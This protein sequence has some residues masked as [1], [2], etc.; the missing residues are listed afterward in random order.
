[1][2]STLV[3]LTLNEIQAIKVLFPRLPIKLFDEVIVVDGGSTD[4][5]IEFFK[6]QGISV[7]VQNKPG[8]GYAYWFGAKKAQGELIVFFSGDGNERAGDISRMLQAISRGADMVT[9]TRFAKESKSFDAT[10]LR[11]LGNK[12]FV[13]LVN[14]LFGTRLTDV[15]NAFRAVK[16]QSFLALNLESTG[17]DTEIEMTIKMIKKGYKIEEI[18]T[19][20]MDRIGG[21]AKLQTVRDGFLNLT[22]VMKEKFPIH[23]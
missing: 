11:I 18:P 5:T 21:E 8:H 9:A 20:E 15:L 16:R 1:M 6:E 10:P 19:I 3:I 14:L 2:K 22:R 4:G 17:F 12:F 7:L 13:F 23:E